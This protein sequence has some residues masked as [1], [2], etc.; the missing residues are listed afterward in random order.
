[1]AP[2]IYREDLAYPRQC[3][4]G[5]FRSLKYP[6]IFAF[7]QSEEIYSAPNF[8]TKLFQGAVWRILR[9]VFYDA[10]NQIIGVLSRTQRIAFD[11]DSWTKFLGGIISS[12]HV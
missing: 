8:N 2:V 6:I 5:Y 4:S 3:T 10:S 11:I 12:V 1:M 9:Y 7:N